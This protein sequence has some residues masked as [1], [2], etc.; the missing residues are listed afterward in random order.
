MILESD[1]ELA[2]QISAV[3][4]GYDIVFEQQVESL[5]GLIE[6]REPALLLIDTAGQPASLDWPEFVLQL[7][8]R[9]PAMKLIFLATQR[10][11]LDELFASGIHDAIQRPID[12]QQLHWLVDQAHRWRTLQQWRQQADGAELQ[13]LGSEIIAGSEAMG[14]VLRQLQRLARVDTT[15]LLMGE[16]GTGK[17]LLVRALHRLS[18]RGDGP[19]VAIN[20]GAIPEPLLESELFGFERGAFTGAGATTPGKIEYASGGI[21]F[22]DEVGDLPLALQAKLLRFLQERVIERLGGHE[23][24]PV[25]LRV[26]CATHRDLPTLITEGRFREDLYYRINETL[27]SVPPLRERTG[28]VLLLARSFLQRFAS[29]QR[30]LLRGFTPQAEAALDAY[31]WPGNVR[32]LENRVRRAVVM[33]DS[34]L[35]DVAEL[36]LEADA[37]DSLDLQQVRERA[38]RQAI[39][40]ALS[41]TDYNLS[42]CADLLGVARPT[43]KQ[44]MRRLDINL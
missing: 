27:L 9:H 35:I 43:L 11:Q 22:L 41:R 32:E 19:L 30:K 31:H 12:L 14:K 29:Q 42:R 8:I 23:S 39:I 13:A 1:T 25:D 7:T 17:E 4:A 3:L 37:Q 6:E 28:D 34:P 2:R 20:C 38:E 10:D 40:R 24:I 5:P 26:V 15:T 44:L 33:T 36:Q 16:S 21:L 18:A